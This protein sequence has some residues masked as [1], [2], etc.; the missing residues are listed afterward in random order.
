MDRRATTEGE[1]NRQASEGVDKSQWYDNNAAKQRIFHYQYRYVHN[2]LHASS[3]ENFTGAA[4]DC[5]TN[6]ELKSK[7]KMNLD[8]DYRLY[9]EAFIGP[10][11]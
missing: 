5:S 11:Y 7:K 3:A 9:V 2:M 4:A 6:G 1:R 10:S 8:V